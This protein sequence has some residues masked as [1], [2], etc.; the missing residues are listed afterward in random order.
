MKQSI[1]QLVLGATS[2]ALLT[3]SSQAA[4]IVFTDTFDSGT[5]SWFKGGTTGTLSNSSSQLS[6]ATSGTNDD[7]YSIGRA[8]A[9]QTLE[10]GQTIRVTMDYTQNAATANDII[11]VGFHNTTN[12]ISADAWSTS[13]SGLGATTGYYGFLRDNATVS[14]LRRESITDTSAVANGPTVSATG[15][16]SLTSLAGHNTSFDIVQDTKYQL[17]F[18]LTRTSLTEMSAAYTLSTGSTV[19]QN[20]TGISTVLHN[21]FDAIVIRPNGPILLD[22]IEVTVIPEPSAALLGGLG[23]LALLR[24][25]R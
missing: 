10:V 17:A 25:R 9:T 12:T 2:L 6:W 21:D 16:N 14:G 22:N 15:V 1:K 7:N 3:V 20:M 5:G 23:L 4:T 13:G 18:E 11:R 19:H 24:R 8:F